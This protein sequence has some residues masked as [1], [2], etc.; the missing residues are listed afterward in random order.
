MLRLEHLSEGGSISLPQIP[1]GS[2]SLPRS[3]RLGSGHGEGA[4]TISAWDASSEETLMQDDIET[5]AAWGEWVL[6][7]HEQLLVHLPSNYRVDF[8]HMNTSASMLD[9][10]FQV[11]RKGF[12][13][14]EAV[15]Q[16]ITA[17]ADIF[18]PQAYL[19]TDGR[20]QPFNAK[21]KLK[22]AQTSGFRRS[23]PKN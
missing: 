1:T 4:I 10:V 19:C 17:L 14:S 23:R 3:L 8:E 20:E 22:A 7:P 12:I 15:G 9:L 18:D 21:D 6:D 2:I 16:F 5:L 11:E 13:S